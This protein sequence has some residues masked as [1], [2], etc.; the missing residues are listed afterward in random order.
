M[1]YERRKEFFFG[2]IGEGKWVF[3]DNFWR[4]KGWMGD[5]NRPWIPPR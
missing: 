5:L 4:E 1:L 2:G 3:G